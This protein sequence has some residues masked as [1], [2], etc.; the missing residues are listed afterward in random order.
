MGKKIIIIFN[1][2]LQV[3][4]FKEHVD[5]MLS[6]TSDRTSNYGLLTYAMENVGGVSLFE[7][8][9]GVSLFDNICAGGR[10]NSEVA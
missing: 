3:V 6:D 5:K 8:Q 4:A 9:M 2:F 7:Q 1:I 10:C